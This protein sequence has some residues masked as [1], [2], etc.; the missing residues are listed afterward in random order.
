MEVVDEELDV[1]DGDEV[2]PS[3]RFWIACDNCEL[4]R[5]KAVLLAMLARPLPKLASAEPMASITEL[6]AACE[7]LALCC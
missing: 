1:E 6:V 4:T 2:V 7:L 5:L 3:S